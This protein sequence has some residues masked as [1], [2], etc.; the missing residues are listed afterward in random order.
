M[1]RPCPGG[2][3]ALQAPS[4]PPASGLA[5]RSQK[6][7]RYA[8]RVSSP[9]ARGTGAQRHSHFGIEPG[10]APPPLSRHRISD[11]SSRTSKR[12]MCACSPGGRERD[13]LHLLALDGH[14][15]LAL[16]CVEHLQEQLRPKAGVGALLQHCCTSLSRQS[17]FALS[18]SAP[19]T[20]MAVA[21]HEQYVTVT[22]HTF[23]IQY[24]R[25]VAG[26]DHPFWSVH[27]RGHEQKQ[28]ISQL[29]TNTALSIYTAA[30]R[31]SPRI[32]RRRHISPLS[33]ASGL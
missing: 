12:S 9:P 22:L 17:S 33:Q 5:P 31:M 29:V 27:N 20:Q 18:R 32:C 4:S 3:A 16:A 30:L 26:F 21:S 24:Y 28:L 23:D 15:P 8:P 25:R 6:R 10:W 19:A 7:T 2:A 11:R 14:R 13:R 1:P